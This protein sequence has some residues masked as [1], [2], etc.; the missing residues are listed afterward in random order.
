MNL[1]KHIAATNSTSGANSASAAGKALSQQDL[2]AFSNIMA[3]TPQAPATAKSNAELTAKISAYLKDH[4]GIA[5]K[6]EGKLQNAAAPA[7]KGTRE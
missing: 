1:I 7:G 3:S 5:A 4:P 2:D 6:L